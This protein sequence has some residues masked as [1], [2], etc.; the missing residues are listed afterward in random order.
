VVTKD[1]AGGMYI[2]EAA[3]GLGYKY[4]WDRDGDGVWDN[5]QLEQDETWTLLQKV[6]VQVPPGQETKVRV[7]VQNA[8][9]MTKIREIVLR[10]PLPDKSRPDPV[11]M[12]V[13]IEVMP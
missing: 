9:K 6:Q 2:V 4:R 11:G 7:E 13:P 8:F 12:N 5:P 3:P 10:R 1:E